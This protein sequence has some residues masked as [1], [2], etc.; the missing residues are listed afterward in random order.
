MI[1]ITLI[2]LSGL[3]LLL[4]ISNILLIRRCNVLSKEKISAVIEKDKVTEIIPGDRVTFKTSL[5]FGK[6]DKSSG[7]SFEVQYEAN[8]IDVSSSQLKVDPYDVVSA[9]F[10]KDL[11]KRP[12][13]KQEIYNVYKGSWV[14]RDRISLLIDKEDIR[15]N[16][17]NK[18]LN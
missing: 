7:V 11:I 16:K 5:T 14:D 8:V 18:I 1:E 15:Q 2:I 4:F 9:Q 3:C 17:I 13:Y 12:N 10:P 6:T